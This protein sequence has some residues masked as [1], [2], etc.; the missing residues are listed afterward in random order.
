MAS[1]TTASA[2]TPDKILQLGMAFWGSKVLLTAV[3]LG[4]FTEV[5]KRPASAEDLSQ[6]LG[7]AA[8]GS[9]DFLDALVALGMLERKD[10]IYKNT[11]ES[12]IYLDREK[13]TYIGGF[14][15]MVNAR[16]YKY[17][18]RLTDAVRTGGP[19]N[20][21]KNGGKTFETFYEDP[22][23]MRQFLQGMTGISGTVVQAI[24]EKFPWKK[25]KTFADI[26]AAQGGLSVGVAGA[27]AHLQGIGFDLPMVKPVFDEFIA[28]RGLSNRLT[29]QGGDFFEEPLP[30]ADVLVMGHI[31]HDWDLEQKLMLVRKAFDALP[32]GGALLVYDAMIDNDRRSNA[33]G[34]LMSLNMLIETAGGFDYTTEDCESW[35]RQAGFSDVHVEQLTP[36]YSMCVGIKPDH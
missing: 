28:E 23:R 25:Y 4:V 30:A 26:G 19:Q 22:N 29:F 16:L 32:K 34:L 24:A 2:V 18:G 35:M 17:W 21:T 27:H 1:N 3:E 13:P 6:R 10:G 33:F 11:E 12:A 36:T 31:L 15:E 9:R 5:A 20:E 8:R 7:L 14:L